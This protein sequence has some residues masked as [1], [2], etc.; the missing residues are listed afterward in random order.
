MRNT[1]L[2]LNALL[3]THN[4]P[5]NYSGCLMLLMCTAGKHLQHLVPATRG[6]PRLLPLLPWSHHVVWGRRSVPVPSRQPSHGWVSF[7]GFLSTVYTQQRHGYYPCIGKAVEG[8]GY[9]LFYGW[10]GQGRIKRFV[11][12][13]HFSS[14]GPFRDSKK[15]CWN[16]RVLSIIRTNGDEGY[17]RINKKHG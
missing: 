15:Y 3:S 12:P 14:L 13:R 17:A 9:D 16:Y 5:A 11:G 10:L 6:I 8:G 7:N 4:R 1:D 2:K